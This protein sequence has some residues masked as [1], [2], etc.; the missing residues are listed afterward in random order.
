MTLFIFSRPSA[1]SELQCGTA[2]LEKTRSQ[3][4]ELSGLKEPASF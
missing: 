3:K 1:D 2:E 4:K